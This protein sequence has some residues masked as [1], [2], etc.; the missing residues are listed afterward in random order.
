MRVRIAVTG[1][2]GF[3]GQALCLRLARDGHA[4]RAISRTPIPFSSGIESVAAGDL[5]ATD[6]APLFAGCDAVVNCAARVHVLR[7]EEEAQARDAFERHNHH[8]PVRLATTARNEGVSRFVQLSS[9]AA[10]TSTTPPGTVVDDTTK[11]L[12]PCSP[13]GW[14]KRYADEKLA[15]LNSGRFATVAL[16]PPAVYGPG[17]GAF[18]ARLMGAAKLGLPLPVGG[19]DNARSFILLDNLLDA[20]ACAIERPVAGKFIVT[21]SPP[22]STAAL[23]RRL[24]ALYGHPDRV[25]RWPAAPVHAAARLLL[26]QRASS[27]LGDAAFS[28]ERFAREFGWTAP[29]TMNEGLRLTVEGSR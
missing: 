12:R 24:L 3:V 26:R 4:V 25:W 14:A 13:Y 28:G 11:E 9:V 6:A 8:L 27:L 21:D 19:I 10:I 29:V 23:Y 17:V 22:L 5:L 20:I 7:R 15:A 18:F 2:G 1:A 16:R